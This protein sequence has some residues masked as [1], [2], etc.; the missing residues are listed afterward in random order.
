MR[1]LNWINVIG[2]DP[3][4]T[5]CPAPAAGCWTFALVFGLAY[6]GHSPCYAQPAAIAVK[7]F[8]IVQGAGSLTFDAA[9]EEI[10]FQTAMDVGAVA[11]SYQEQ[12]KSLG[13]EESFQSIASFF[14]NL[15]WRKDRKTIS[16]NIKRDLFGK[17]ATVT[18]SGDGLLWDGKPPSADAAAKGDVKPAAPESRK[19]KATETVAQTGSIKASDFPL[20]EAQSKS[21]SGS[22]EMIEFNSRKGVAE[23]VEFHTRNLTEK[24]WTRTL[25][26]EHE[27][28]HLLRFEK[29]S[30]Y[31][32][33]GL[34]P[35][36]FSDNLGTH[37][38]AMGAV[39]GTGLTWSHPGPY[40]NVPERML[41]DYERTLGKLSPDAREKF[42]SGMRKQRELKMTGGR[43]IPASAWEARAEQP[44]AADRPKT[45][46]PPAVAAAPSGDSE[47]SGTFW[48]GN[49]SYAL[50]HAIAY[51]TKFF[52][53]PC[54]AVVLTAQP[55]RPRDLQELTNLLQ[56]KGSDE[57]FFLSGVQIKVVLDE[58]NAVRYVF[59]WADNV[60]I[61]RSSGVEAQ[62]ERPEGRI[63]GRFTMPENTVFR[64]MKCRFEA[65]FNVALMPVAAP[66][67]K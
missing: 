54:T 20:L 11:K 4:A 27:G 37:Q 51:R 48:L 45:S 49:K 38:G 35:H 31:L 65:Q 29:E 13:W 23:N 10:R 43:D 9:A 63:K 50:K 21:T 22:N 47:C 36:E 62:V 44:L 67:K 12:M 33:I 26:A 18:I 30:T 19:A 55:I 53:D 42:V 56:T 24:G 3:C 32:R 64:D 28:L 40:G 25:S 5:R 39:E 1:N 16:I 52:D 61:N 7:D 41:K 8:P 34:W 46:A 17:I 15:K 6:C 60:S 57:A 66:E 58:E 59:A 2:A 14:A